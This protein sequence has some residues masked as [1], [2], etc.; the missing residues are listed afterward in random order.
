MSHIQRFGDAHP[1]HSRP[2]VGAAGT[3]F[4]GPDPRKMK[5]LGMGPIEPRPSGFF[6]NI[7]HPACTWTYRNHGLTIYNWLSREKNRYTI[8]SCC[9]FLSSNPP[10]IKSYR[11]VEKRR[12]N[13]LYVDF[14]STVFR[15]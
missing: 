6:S 11:L 8:I 14:S 1:P 10:K 2:Q 3:R 4:L 5:N 12:T 15:F 9:L 7:Q 13:V